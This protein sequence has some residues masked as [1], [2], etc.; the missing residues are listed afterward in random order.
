MNER[1]H[2]KHESCGGIGPSESEVEAVLA[3]WRTISADRLEAP[4]K[5]LV[6][7]R[8]SLISSTSEEWS[9]AVHGDAAAAV[10]LALRMGKPARVTFRLDLVMTLLLRA[11]CE[12]SAAALVMA[13]R[14]NSMPLDFRIRSG[15]ATS[16]LIHCVWLGSRR[17]DRPIA[18]HSPAG[19][20]SKSKPEDERP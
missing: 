8:A 19:K 6:Q 9:R 1:I 16:W 14:L 17:R 13:H 15:L 18:C 2:D 10:N 3:Y 20:P 11:A 7:E 12:D 5:Q 4:Q